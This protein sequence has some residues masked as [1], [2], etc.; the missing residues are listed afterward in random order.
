MGYLRILKLGKKIEASKYLEGDTFTIVTVLDA[1][2]SRIATAA[3]KWCKDWEEG[4]IITN[5][6]WEKRKIKKNEG[7]LVEEWF[8]HEMPTQ[9]GSKVSWV[10]KP[11][12]GKNFQSVGYITKVRQSTFGSKVQKLG[13]Q[14]LVDTDEYVK[15]FKKRRAFIAIDKLTKLTR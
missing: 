4:D 9:L 2:T 15:L 5:A 8:L 11:H 14:I 6:K 12:N 10:C 7:T 1:T 13:A 3:G